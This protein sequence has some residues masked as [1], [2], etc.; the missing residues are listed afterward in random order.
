MSHGALPAQRPLSPNPEDV[1]A[2][3]GLQTA[4]DTHLQCPPSPLPPH[5]PKPA[6]KDM[7][8]IPRALVDADATHT[9]DT[10]ELQLTA[11]QPQESRCVGAVADR[12]HPI[13]CVPEPCAS[14]TPEVPAR[15][16]SPEIP[17]PSAHC[18]LPAHRPLSPVGKAIKALPMPLRHVSTPDM[19]RVESR[20]LLS[21]EVEG[22]SQTVSPSREAAHERHY[23]WKLGKMHADVPDYKRSQPR[24]YES[25][26]CLGT[27]KDQHVVT[28]K[29]AC[30]RLHA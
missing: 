28:L 20:Y 3:R 21:T 6:D 8:E 2:L 18:S 15:C 24:M 27:V 1:A 4:P 9:S 11:Y 23:L 10:G 14:R 5:Q 7:A 16:Y 30:S 22:P 29:Q 26:H 17:T 19:T 13:A 12:Q 25:S